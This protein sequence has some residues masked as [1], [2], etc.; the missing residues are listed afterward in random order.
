MRE[1]GGR[2]LWSSS[3]PG[4][5]LSHDEIVLAGLYIMFEHGIWELEI[6]ELIK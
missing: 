6:A 2:D 4:L 3:G 1:K 5:S